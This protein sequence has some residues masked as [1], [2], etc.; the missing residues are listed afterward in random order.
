MHSLPALACP[1]RLCRA[2]ILF[3]GVVWGLAGAARSQEQEPTPPPKPPDYESLLKRLDE[4]EAMIRELAEKEKQRTE[5][6][7]AKKPPTFE[8]LYD[9]GFIL[10]STKEAKT[11]FELRINGRMQFRYTGFATANDEYRNL[12]TRASTSGDPI[13]VSDLNEF[14]IERGRLEFRVMALDPK[15]RFFMNLDSDT[16]DGHTVIFHDFWM[17]YAFDPAFDLYVGKAFV[18]GS[19]DW[20]NGSLRTQLADR[21]LATTYFRPDRSVGIWAIGQPIEGLWYRAMVGNGLWASDLTPEQ[22]NT[23][24]AYAASIWCEPFGKYG[25][26]YADLEHSEEL[27]AQMGASF[28]FGEQSGTTQ[29]GASIAESRFLRLS[30]G[31]RLTSLGVDHADEYLAAFDAA[32]KFQG[33]SLNSE[34]FHRWLREIDPTGPAPTGFPERS[35]ED[36]G[37]YVDAGFFLIEKTLEPAVR[38]SAIYGSQKKSS[39]YA[40]ALNLFLDGTHNN[41]LTLE[42][43]W[44]DGS[45]VQNTGANFRIGDDGFRVIAQWQVAF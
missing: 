3:S 19:R 12:E 7:A 9:K 21:S 1:S 5:A 35:Q 2:A 17:N 11:P 22:V 30:D 39:E 25:Q 40:C 8:A 16:D 37:F 45:P 27:V 29:T 28:A 31:S 34:V 32:F 44:Y 24:F 23:E 18:P 14:E 41:K 42:G 38:Y 20:L 43:G 4:Q 33:A 15:L 26:S 13:A 36:W 10:R 6:D